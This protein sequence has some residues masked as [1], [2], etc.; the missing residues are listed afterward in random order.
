MAPTVPRPARRDLTARERSRLA[1]ADAQLRKRADMA[2]AARLSREQTI[3]DVYAA[4]ASVE[5]M[6]EA[7]GVTPEAVYRVIRK[8]RQGRGMT[9]P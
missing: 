2:E 3:R 5:Q 1:S 6:A 9:R 7:L 4:G 8:A